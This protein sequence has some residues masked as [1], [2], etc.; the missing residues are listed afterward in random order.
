[1]QDQDKILYFLRVV[2]PTI[3]SKVAKNINSEILIA[4]AYLS[5]LS[6]QG[7]VKISHLKIGGSPLYYLP[8][9]EEQLYHFAAGNLNPKDFQVLER[10]KLEKV[11]RE[12]SIDLLSKVSLRSLQ[13][14]A[15]PLHVTVAG[16]RELFWKWHLLSDPETTAAIKSALFGE[17]PAPEQ[18]PAV[19][20]TE[21][22]KQGRSPQSLTP[23]FE[24]HKEPET[25][26][27]TKLE[28]KPETKLEK[29]R[30]KIA[31]EPAPATTVLP[32]SQLSVPQPSVHHPHEKILVVKKKRPYQKNISASSQLIPLV[33]QYFR[34]CGIVVQEQEII[35]RNA[36]INFLLSVP[37]VVGA[38]TYFCKTKKKA[39]CDEGD[40]SSAYM[41]AQIKKLPLLF[42]YT[43]ELNKKA[44]EMLATDAFRNA[45]VKKLVADD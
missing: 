6:A 37:S 45:I 14:F 17:H 1:M 8:G 43:Q 25:K 28:T 9:Q 5:D 2:G 12:N 41:E 34:E 35:R 18:K 31:E 16:N 11:L 4:S 39:R 38:L 33:E 32:F 19:Q 20:D 40:L 7:K 10:L 22:D 15:V 27:E 30:P 24:E 29:P 23:V 42:L 36:E 21:Q 3:P 44:Q 26:S 13:D